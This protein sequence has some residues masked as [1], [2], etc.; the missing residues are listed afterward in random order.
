MG[1]Q[2]LIVFAPI[3]LGV[4]GRYTISS[5]RAAEQLT[6]DLTLRFFAP[7]L[8]FVSLISAPAGLSPDIATLSAYALSALLAGLLVW[9]VLRVMGKSPDRRIAAAV[10]SS[11]G[12]QLFFGV[13]LCIGVLGPQA[14]GPAAL[15]AVFAY[16]TA[17][18]G[19]TLALALSKTG[20]VSPAA[21]TAKLARHVLG[22]PILW[23]V[24]LALMLGWTGTAVT[25]PLLIAL[26]ALA[27]VAA[28]LALFG[29]GL[30][31]GLIVTPEKGAAAV[32]RW[33][34]I[35]TSVMIVVSKLIIAPLVVWGFANAG[36]A[37][38]PKW[39]QPALLIAATPTA[40]L[41]HLLVNLYAPEALAARLA[42]LTT[43]ALALVTIPVW[44]TVL[45]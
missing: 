35:T 18:V 17:M 43:T 9:A 14:A 44:I 5:P 27:A 39:W 37:G 1:W 22:S 25:G 16:L 31:I 34:D 42:I 2:V 19:A 23:P 12:N 4:A 40:V 32:S 20:S 3:L 21:Q 11:Y 13:P 8:V 38:D 41:A 6:G 33:P 26:E 24:P 28:P 15:I 7:P 29:V 45:G 30:T 10:V 36:W